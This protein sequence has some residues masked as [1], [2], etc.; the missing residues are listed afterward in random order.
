MPPGQQEL[1]TK[2]KTEGAEQTAKAHDQL[3]GAQKKVVDGTKEGAGATRDAAGAQDKL[4]ASEG[5][6]IGLLSAVHPA[7]GQFV[8]AGL[9]ASKVAGDLATKNIN[10]KE[11]MGKVTAA[12]KGNA[13]ALA[14]IGAGG[15]VVLALLAI[16]KAWSV[17]KEK[18]ERAT[19]AARRNREEVNKNKKEE[20]DLKTAIEKVA[21]IVRGEAGKELSEVPVVCEV[22]TD[23][24]AGEILM[25]CTVYIKDVPK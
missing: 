18:A 13:K 4:N 8:D 10:L 2:F 6:F 20:E 23:P 12:I 1:T 5:D 24:E 11:V 9:K 7:L 17:I 22:E 15:A 25:L 16:A 14:L 21:D 19:E 3:A